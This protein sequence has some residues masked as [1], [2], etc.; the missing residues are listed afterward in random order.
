MLL[1]DKKLDKLKKV[2]SLLPTVKIYWLNKYEHAVNK[3]HGTETLQFF[4]NFDASFFNFFL[5]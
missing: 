3:I 4:G 1:R 2:Q 5:K